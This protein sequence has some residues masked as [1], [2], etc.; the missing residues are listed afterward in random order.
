MQRFRITTY[1]MDGDIFYGQDRLELIDAAL[2]S[3]F[4]PG[5]FKNSK[6]ASSE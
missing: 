5:A 3:P 2:K 4:K 6:V 1:F